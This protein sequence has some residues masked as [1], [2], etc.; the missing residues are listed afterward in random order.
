M[1]VDNPSRLDHM[2]SMCAI[3]F[4]FQCL[5]IYLLRR[6]YTEH[7]KKDSVFDIIYVGDPDLN[8]TRVICCFLLHVTLLPEIQSAK[9]MLSFAK[10]NPNAF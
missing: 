5:L 7:G 4:I 3:C 1:Q 8:L 6:E 2:V 10:K 9:K